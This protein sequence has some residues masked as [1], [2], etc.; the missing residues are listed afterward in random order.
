MYTQNG[1]FGYNIYMLWF[2]NSF[3]YAL[4]SILLFCLLLG[5]LATSI[6]I[7][8]AQPDKLEAQLVKS[9]IYEGV[10][11]FAQEK[12]ST[13]SKD[14]GNGISLSDPAVV[15][16]AKTALPTTYLEK[17]VNTFLDS[18][19]AWLEGKTAKPD[20]S[21]DL[22]TPKIAFAQQI[23]AAVTA[24]LAGLPTCTTAQAKEL[25]DY[26]PLTVTCR[27]ASVNAT[28][29][30]NNIT[31]K[32]LGPDGLFPNPVYT[33]DSISG[34]DKQPYYLDSAIQQAPKAY[35]FATKLPL[36]IGGLA[37]LSA[38]GIVFIS[39]RKRKG[40]RRIAFALVISG[41]I[42]VAIK[43]GAD[44]I[45]K[46]SEGKLFNGADFNSLREPLIAFVRLF[47]DQLMKINLYIGIAYLVLA[48]II[49]VS[50]ITTHGRVGNKKPETDKNLMTEE[51]PDPEETITESDIEKPLAPVMTPEEK[52]PAP[53]RPNLIQ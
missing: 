31:Q 17:Q 33:A 22:T 14:G 27:P 15:N 23:G 51:V 3:V 45:L 5:A 25:G 24:N 41:S 20:F 7:A 1:G 40:L 6:N 50:L 46:R 10:V 42:L 43:I 53:K 34:K 28:A 35:Q 9:G 21:I 12:A 52:K 38:I 11:K 44:Y 2:R 18:N 49:F 19:Y 39:S 36:A 8:I 47:E 32:M 29:E 48:G 30:G 26:N 16:A 4:S 37:L 13:A